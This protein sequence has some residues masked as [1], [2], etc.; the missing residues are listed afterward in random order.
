MIATKRGEKERF[1]VLGRTN[2]K[3]V[4][5]ACLGWTSTARYL[6]GWEGA[7]CDRGSSYIFLEISSV[8]A[9]AVYCYYHTSTKK[10]LGCR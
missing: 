7:C 1:Q 10:K 9:K 6:A 2:G 5:K 3:A 8:E 4:G